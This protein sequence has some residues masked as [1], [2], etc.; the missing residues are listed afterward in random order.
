MIDSLSSPIPWPIYFREML[1]FVLVF[2]VNSSGSI[3]KEKLCKSR[4]FNFTFISPCKA[5][6]KK[7]IWQPVVMACKA[8]S[9]LFLMHLVK[10]Y[11]AL[12]TTIST[13]KNNFEGG[14]GKLRFTLFFFCFFVFVLSLRTEE[15][16]TFVRPLK[17]EYVVCCVFRAF[18]A[19]SLG[20]FI[21][22][23]IAS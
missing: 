20:S 1:I 15:N 21:F 2:F 8:L 13:M 19:R 11:V 12:P 5:G 22:Y 3:L 14:E 6:T 10:L 9:I 16:I 18:R 23:F 7:F 17:S 4:N